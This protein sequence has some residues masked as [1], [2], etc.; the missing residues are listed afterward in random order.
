M[1]VPVVIS[2]RK[3]EKIQRKVNPLLMSHNLAVVSNNLKIQLAQENPLSAKEK[4]RTIEIALYNDTMAVSNKIQI[5][6]N[7]ASELPTERMYSIALGLNTKT[8][9]SILKLKIYDKDDLLN[10]LIE[11][12]VKNNTLIER[13]F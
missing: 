5:T 10:P 13:D 1:I 12:N 3:E 11:E 4:E 2:S 8:T 7:S 6:L 9:E